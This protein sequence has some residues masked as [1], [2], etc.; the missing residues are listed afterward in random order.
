MW[1]ASRC[2]GPRSSRDGVRGLEPRRGELG[3]PRPEDRTSHRNGDRCKPWDAIFNPSPTGLPPRGRSH[4][5]RRCPIGLAPDGAGAVSRIR[6]DPGLVD[7]RRRHGAGQVRRPLV[8][9]A[10]PEIVEGAFRTLIS[11][12]AG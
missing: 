9:D 5:G 3:E 12:T 2:G 7:P 6:P 1:Y 10:L 11:R 8:R 4:D